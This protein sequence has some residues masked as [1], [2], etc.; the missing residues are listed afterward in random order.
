MKRNVIIAVVLIVVVLIYFACQ[1]STF[2]EVVSVPGIT[3]GDLLNPV[4]NRF[5]NRFETGNTF[6]G[7]DIHGIDAIYVITMPQRKAYISEQMKKLG[8]KCV[9]FNAIKPSDLST[10]DQDAL[11]TVNIPGT[12]IYK[13]YTRLAVGLSFGMCFMDSLVKGY[14]NIMVFEDDL[15]IETSSIGEGVQEFLNS[16]C[17]IFYMGYCFAN[18][19]NVRDDGYRHL[20]EL[21]DRNILCCHSLCIKTWFLPQLIDYCFPMKFNSDEQFR[22]FYILNKINVC[23]PRTVYF[24]QNRETVKSL[25]ESRD[26]P[27]FFKTCNLK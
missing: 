3:K 14:K 19:G 12:Q 26:D 20:V 7:K 16:K 25:N 23:I 9:Y 18:C 10:R 13:K 2:S 15:V 21:T 11:S 27:E 17:D 5:K 22:N 24:K 8:V 6:F 4:Y 1:K